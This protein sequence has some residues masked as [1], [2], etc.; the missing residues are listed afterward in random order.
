MAK[1]VEEID[2]EVE[3]EEEEDEPAPA[4]AVQ[5]APLRKPPK[6]GKGIASPPQLPREVELLWP[7]LIED[8]EK[9]GQ[10]PYTVRIQVLQ[11]DPP[12]GNAGDQVSLGAFSGGSVAGTP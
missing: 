2:L 10:S 4:P 12:M 11:I 5:A 7:V 3:E 8:L 1:P 9:Q 6:R